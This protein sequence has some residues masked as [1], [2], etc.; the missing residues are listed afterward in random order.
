MRLVVRL[1]LLPTREQRAALLDTLALC[2]EGANLISD[3]AHSTP[4]RGKFALQ[5]AKYQDLKALGLA[6]QASVRVLSKVADAY[7]AQR[8]AIKSGALSGK[9]REKATSTP[10]FF[11]PGAAQAFDDRNLSWQLDA[12]TV[13]I[14]TTAGRLKG[15]AFTGAPGDLERLRS[16]RRGE[17]DLV[18]D[19]GQLYLLAGV[20]VPEEPERE[21]EDYLAFDSG[22]VNIATTSDGANWSGGAVTARRKRNRALRQKLQRKGTKSAK[23]LLRK[24]SKKEARFA[25]DVNHQISK[26]IVTEAE[27]TGRG[28]A[29]EDLSGIRDRARLS[30]PQ[31]TELHSWAFAQLFAFVGYKAKLRG[32]PVVVVDAAYS[33][34]LCPQ[35]GTV[36]RGNRPDRDTFRCSGCGHS[37]PADLVAARNIRAFALAEHAKHSA[38]PPL[39]AA[40]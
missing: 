9:R 34:Q 31:R 37:G 30:K 36:G 3:Y 22:I 5:N 14:W 28:I 19:D 38:A 35:C 20:E 12:G 6:A 26:K 8:G 39:A 11:R 40:A 32:V 15:V 10:I 18:E 27:R 17:S 25:A 16:Y 4:N 21:V 24:R 1:T 33:S 29:R 2:N 23:R 7:S 13:S